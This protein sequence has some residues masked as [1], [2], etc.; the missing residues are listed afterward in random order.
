MAREKYNASNFCIL[1]W[2][3]GWHMEKMML[4]LFETRMMTSQHNDDIIDGGKLG[5][6]K[7]GIWKK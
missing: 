2:Q 7:G 1:G 5:G 6:K 4:Q 3:E